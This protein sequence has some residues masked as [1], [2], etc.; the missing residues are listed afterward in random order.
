M[1]TSYI[2]LFTPIALVFT[3]V[4]ASCVK[5][6][7]TVPLDPD[8]ITSATVF[9]TLDG[10]TSVLAKAYAGLALSGQQGPAGMP[11]ISGIDEGFSTYLRQYWKAQELPTDEAV[12]AWND[13]N[14]R[15]YHEQ[16]W[17]ESNEFITAMYNRIYL[18]VSYANE[19]LRE[20]TE[21]KLSER[22]FSEA[23]KEIIRGYRAEA[24]FLRALSYYHAID[25]FGSVPFVTEN[26]NVGAFLPE[27]ISRADLFEYVEQELLDIE[28][29]LPAPRTND[30]GRA[31]RAAAW[32][33]L[34]KLYLNAEV[35][36]GTEK[37]TECITYC[38][39]IIDAGYDLDPDYSHLFLADNHTAEGIIFPVVFDGTN[40]Q[41][42]GGMTF[43][44]HAAVGGSMNVA[45]YGIDF[46]WGGTRVTS[47]FVEK[48]PDP[49]GATDKRAMFYTN[50]QSLE[51]D[52][53]FD[54]T[55]GYAIT[56]F[57]NVT[58][59]G[60][61]GSNITYVDTDYP[62]FRLADVYLMLAEAVLRG[63]EGATAGEA[64][65]YVNEV[66]K[67]AYGDDSGNIGGGDLTLSFI[68]DERAREL[69]WEGHRRTDL[70]RFGKFS[71]TDYL[72]PW[73][74]GVPEG[75]AVDAKYDLFPLPAADIGANPNL[76]QNPDY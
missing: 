61:P 43:V 74:G 30:Y 67:R 60:Q 2:K 57:K 1:K 16:D 69:Y 66:R 75:T 72:W 50:G 24:R 40:A 28:S 64:L 76:E 37:Y 27:Q 7:D 70:I 8:E 11:D 55:H 29:L 12:I 62:L 35:Y 45:D 49:S 6:L 41:T 59:G 32:M 47:K 52:D 53:V 46:G 17:S 10:Y 25:M 65:F 54:F 56:K 15:D 3:L 23:D 22:G 34:A 48:F 36:I 68:L 42:W 9:E 71:D 21:E 14:L 38:K 63:G 26:D 73:K 31:D 5:D 13:G 33:L 44:V 4:L 51:I 20:S 19:F 58:S 39:N 18:Q